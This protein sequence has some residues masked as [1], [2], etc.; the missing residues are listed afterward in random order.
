VFES[1]WHVLIDV[2]ARRRNACKNHWLRDK[3]TT[4]IWNHGFIFYC[5]T[6][7]EHRTQGTI[8]NYLYKMLIAFKVVPDVVCGL[9]RMMG[10]VADIISIT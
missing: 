4:R 3:L 1:M 5:A 7:N 9:L 6:Q 10:K 8:T 2:T